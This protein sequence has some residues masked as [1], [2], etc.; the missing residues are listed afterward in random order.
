MSFDLSSKELF[1]TSDRKK[2]RKYLEDNFETAKELWLVYPMTASGEKCLPY[3]DAV[4]EALCFG[5]IDSTIKHT[6]EL[7]RAQRFT[8]RRKNSPYSQPNIERLIWLDERGMIHP[9]VRDGILPVIKAPFVFPKDV[10]KELKKDKEVW[11]NYEGFSE[12]YKRIRIAYIEAA[13]KR[14]EEFKKRLNNFIQKTK[15][16]KIIQ[17]YGGIEKYYR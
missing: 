16:G 11:K 13:R 1:Y 7:H 12:P 8:P 10:L 9:K 3:N 6:D 15:Q 14:P 5:W 17:G 4:E 2:W